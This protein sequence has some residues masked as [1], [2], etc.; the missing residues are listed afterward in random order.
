MSEA[1]KPKRP[2]FRNIH[3][4]QI[5]GYRM[6]LT[7][8]VS[9]M[10][11]ISGLFLFLMLPLILCLLDSSLQS[12]ETFEQFKSFAAHPVAKLVILALSWAYLHHFCAGIRHVA[13]DMHMGV[14]KDTARKSAAS[15]LVISIAL[16]ILV[17][18]KLFG[19]F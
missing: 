18:L 19:V 9:I 17:A 5:V 3:I 2:E 13:M 6:P 1:A 14:D 7:A 8:V 4:T 15:V 10:H 11:R 12:Q 16:M